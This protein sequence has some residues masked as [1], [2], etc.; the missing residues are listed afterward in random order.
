MKRA[1]PPSRVRHETNHPV[2]SIRIPRELHDKLAEQKETAG[3]SVADVLKVGLEKAL[4]VVDKAYMKGYGD[5][6][7]DCLGIVKD[8]NDCYILVCDLIPDEL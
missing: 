7:G 8:C 2:A 5:A 6:L 4:P 1:S 3:L